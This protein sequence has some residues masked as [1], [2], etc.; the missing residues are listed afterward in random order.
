M[1]AEHW[2]IDA[3][4]LWCWRRLLRIP[5]TARSSNQ[6]ILKKINP[7]YSLKD[8]CW[9]SNTWVKSWLTGKD[10]DAGKV[11]GQEEKGGSRG[12]D[13]Q[14]A[15]LTRQTWVW[16]N[17]EIVKAREPWRAAVHG[18]TKNRTPFSDWT[19]S[20]FLKGR[21]WIWSER[22]S[23]GCEPYLGYWQASW[24]SQYSSVEWEHSRS[25]LTDE[26]QT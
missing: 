3:F 24:T 1:K 13:D 2:R 23:S 9:S 14:M 20:Q 10:L 19:T 6:S 5:W 22:G 17:L 15:S 25:Q 18:V 12:R 21:T 16:T 4:K 26:L 8:W 7:E 11:R